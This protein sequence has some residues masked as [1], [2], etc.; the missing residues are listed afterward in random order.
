MIMAAET[1]AA[2]QLPN[3]SCWSNC[4]TCQLSFLS[5]LDFCHMP[6]LLFLLCTLSDETAAAAWWSIADS[7]YTCK[8]APAARRQYTR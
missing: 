2:E 6:K 5:H 4:H 7:W 1:E 3:Q 8:L